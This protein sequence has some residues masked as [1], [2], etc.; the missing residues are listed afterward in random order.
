MAKSAALERLVAKVLDREPI[1][2]DYLDM[3]VTTQ[4][5]ASRARLSVCEA[6]F[7]FLGNND[8]DPVWQ[9][10]REPIGD[11]LANTLKH[12]DS[13]GIAYVAHGVADG[14]FVVIIVNSCCIGCRPRY[15]P[16]QTSEEGHRGFI[17]IKGML[18][19]PDVK[20]RVKFYPYLPP[21]GQPGFAQAIFTIL[22]RATTT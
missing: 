12:N 18:C 19:H 2:L 7:S 9:N 1:G 15:K 21:I 11:A 4:R 20:D 16:L 13:R 8:D 14:R 3:D 22:P 17:I 6:L 10:I 5:S